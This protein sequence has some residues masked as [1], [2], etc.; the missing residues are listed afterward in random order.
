MMLVTR[1]GLG[2]D[3]EQVLDGGDHLAVFGEDLV[4][5]EAGEALQ[6]HLEDA[7]RLHVRQAVAEPREPN[8]FGSD[9]GPE[10][11]GRGARAASPRPAPSAMRGP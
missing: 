4:L 11:L 1:S 7:L 9:S 5:L 3:V 10:L 6:L 8:S 2:E